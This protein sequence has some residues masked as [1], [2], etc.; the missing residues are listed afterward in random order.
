MDRVLVPLVPLVL[1]AC[2][3]P[4]ALQAPPPTDGPDGGFSAEN[5]TT[6]SDR[7]LLQQLM[8]RVEKLEQRCD[9]TNRVAFSASLVAEESDT[10]FGPFN[11]TIV[12]IFRKVTTNI[13]DAYDPDTGV[14]TVP[15]GGVY[16]VRFT[17]CVGKSG[18]LSTALLR[19]GENV[20]GVYEMSGGHAGGSNGM[21]LVLERGDRLWVVLWPRQTAFDQ[22]KLT[23]FSGFLLY[24]MEL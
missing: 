18:S 20:F 2:V 17:G 21:T 5:T 7:E 11:E 19:N 22:S 24:P 1:L 23:T 12:L 6:P 13:G 8:G 16:Y 9:G 15:S 10:F 4:A 14:F 3:G